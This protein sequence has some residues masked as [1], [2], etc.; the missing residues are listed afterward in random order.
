M[1]S[2]DA[3]LLNGKRVAKMGSQTTHCPGMSSIIP[4]W[5]AW[6]RDKLAALSTDV[7]FTKQAGNKITRTATPAAGAK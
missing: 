2:S 7:S 3:V 5:R 6:S 4:V 1:K